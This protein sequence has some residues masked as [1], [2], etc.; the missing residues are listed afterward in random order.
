MQLDADQQRAIFHG[1][2]TYQLI[3]SLISPKKLAEFKFKGII[4][5]V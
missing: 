2:A 4:E 3:Y 5:T 1:Q